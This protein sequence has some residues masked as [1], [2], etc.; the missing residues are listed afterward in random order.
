MSQFN[1]P[2]HGKALSHHR[3]AR[4]GAMRR[5]KAMGLSG[6]AALGLL[7]SPAAFA[8]SLIHI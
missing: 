8:L 6:L 7:A 5:I 1:L 3:H 4:R 2:A